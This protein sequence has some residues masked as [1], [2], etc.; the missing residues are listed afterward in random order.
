MRIRKNTL[1]LLGIAAPVLLSSCYITS[2]GAAFLAMQARA[3][4]TAKL[5]ADPALPADRRAFLE[6]VGRLRRFAV[7]ELGMRDT[8]NYTSFVEVPGDRVATVVQACAELSF[9]RRL[10]SYPVVG[11]L[12][13]KGFFDPADAEKEAARLREEGLDVIVRGVDAFSTLGWFKDP[14]Y[15]FM[16]SYGEAELAELIVHELTHATAFSKREGSFNEELATFVGRAGAG[17]WLQRA[18]E[19]ESEEL[20]A[21]RAS[22]SDAEAFAAFIAGTAA[23]LERLYGETIPDGEKR[24]GKKRIIAERAALYRKTAPEAFS[25]EGYRKVPM[26]KI[27]NAFIDL[28]RLYEGEP[29]LYAD[30]LRKVCGG[31]LRRFIVEAARLAAAE[32]PKDAMRAELASAAGAGD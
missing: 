25:G 17:L 26:E 30:Y 3:K 21:Y 13:Y 32:E 4:P 28:Y 29:A 19:P 6:R 7:E 22:R 15:S 24:E 14:L 9:D 27:N 5:L 31:D 10:W 1:R 16:E 12:P 11:R 18:G 20:K 2:E 8:E 23:E